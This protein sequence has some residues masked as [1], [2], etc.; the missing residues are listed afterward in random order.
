MF[1]IS[2]SFDIYIHIDVYVYAYAILQNSE[3]VFYWLDGFS[4]NE[5][6][7]SI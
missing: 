6:L 4:S 7:W 1:H 5:K 2:N 3:M